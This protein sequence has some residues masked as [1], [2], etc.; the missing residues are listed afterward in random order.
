MPAGTLNH[1]V[2][3]RDHLSRQRYP[4]RVGAG[5]LFRAELALLHDPFV[6][7]AC[8]FDSIFELAV[9]LGQLLGYL[10]CAARGIS[11]EDGRLQ[12]YASTELEFVHGRVRRG[13]WLAQGTHATI[14]RPSSLGPI[15]TL[16]A[17]RLK[18]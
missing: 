7:L 2:A 6:G 17:S 9:S 12:K 10:K 3:R 8:T 16:T 15:G 5:L 18:G 1:R 11:I 13:R 14:F 4:R